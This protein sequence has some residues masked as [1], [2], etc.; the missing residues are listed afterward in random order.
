MKQSH[1]L[2]EQYRN[3]PVLVLGASGFIGRWVARALS[4]VGA[5][6]CLAV[7]D[8]TGAEE[9]FSRYGVRGEIIGADLTNPES[10][11]SLLLDARPSVLFNLA[12]YG[13]DPSERD[14]KAAYQMNADLIRRICQGLV[15]AGDTSWPGQQFV[16]VGSALEYGSLGGDLAEDSAPR[17]TTLYGKSKLRGTQNLAECC[18]NGALRGITARLFTVYGPG[19]HRG[20]LLP[21][22][23]EAARE[24][25]KLALTSGA[26]RRDF[27]YVEDV[28]QGL[29][30]LG[31]SSADP[32]EV[33][34][35]AS[36]RLTTVREFALTAAKVCR[37]PLDRL[38]F[39][40]LATR[41][42][43]ME[44]GGVSLDKLRRLTDWAPPT[45]PQEGIRKTA[46]FCS[47]LR[48]C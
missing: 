5:G 25:G 18:R 30:R 24:S 46:A 41:R 6:L 38:E 42:E 40:R 9:I 45:E 32:G 1:R 23:I 20:R 27:T 21:S 36:G 16:H 35:L 39:G 2:G 12:G 8:A 44:H 14:E 15:S 43:E 37:T 22:L 4:S 48:G 31:V 34:N 26:Q 13:V 11:R 28:A 47:L 3:V 7:R 10:I 29:L 17:P 19:E 33:V